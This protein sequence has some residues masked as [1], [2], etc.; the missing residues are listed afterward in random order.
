[1]GILET[2]QWQTRQDG[3]DNLMLTKAPLSSPGS[4]EVLVEIRAVSLNYRDLEVSQGLYSHHKAI[5]SGQ[6]D[7]LVP[8]SDM[9]GVVVAIGEGV[10]WKIGDRVVSTWNQG[11][12]TGSINPYIMKT[13]LGLPL[14]GVLQTHRVFPADALLKAPDYMSDEEASCLTIAAVTAWMAIN[15]F[16]PLGQPG[17]KGEIVLLQGTGG[18][19]ISGLQIAHA[20][21]AT[22][23][24]TSSSDS[25]LARAKA[26]GANHVINY[27]DVPSWDDEVMQISNNHG[28]DIIFET[29][30]A[31]TIRKSFNSVAYGGMIACIGYVSGKQDDADERTNIN[32]LA[33]S[34]TVTLK[35]IINGP[36]DR[37][38]EMLRFYEQHEIH[39]VIDRVFAFEQGRDAFTYLEGGS[40][41]GKVVI[42]VTS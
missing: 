41:F 25:K 22:T 11:H 7:A 34:R 16:R 30:G 28:A 38:Q 42:K 14:D 6:P 10:A 33:L 32:V 39:P 21:G 12:F 35:G 2:S 9:C 13:G 15:Q 19:S 1:M 26:L 31:K 23:L 36:K 29:G 17:G 27:R 20:A 3:L 4:G 40:H 37:F 24:I 8:C 5:A 18:V